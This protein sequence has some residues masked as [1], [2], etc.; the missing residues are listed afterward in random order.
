[1]DPQLWLMCLLLVLPLLLFI[2]T[3]TRPPGCLSCG[4]SSAPST[5]ALASSSQAHNTTGDRWVGGGYCQGVRVY[6]MWGVGG[7]WT[8]VWQGGGEG[9]G[10]QPKGSGGQQHCLGWWYSM[11][12]RTQTIPHLHMTTGCNVSILFCLFC[13]YNPTTTTRGSSPAPN[14]CCGVHFPQPLH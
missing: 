1:M 12:A 9:L 8:G 11:S 3:T 13:L 2:I 4:V 5:S 6:V 14:P 10:Q 7:G